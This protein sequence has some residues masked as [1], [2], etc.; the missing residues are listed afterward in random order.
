MTASRLL[1]YTTEDDGRLHVRYD[2][3]LNLR[4]GTIVVYKGDLAR[5]VRAWS[6]FLWHS[7]GWTSNLTVT[8]SS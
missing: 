5:V 8:V 2:P 4:R 1:R 6:R 7:L 3:P